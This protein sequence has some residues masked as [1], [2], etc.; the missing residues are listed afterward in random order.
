MG[1]FHENLVGIGPICDAK[2]SV[3]FNDEA[4]HIISPTGT[5]VITGWRE[6]TGHKLWRMSLLPTPENIIPIK[7]K[8]GTKETS[9]AAFS[10]YD[11]PSVEAL[12]RYFHAASGFP[13]RDT[14]L[15]AIKA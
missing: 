7:D 11:L 13:V 1:N 5:P 2:Y 4:V 8:P 14:W 15:K 9:L 3:L 10:A 6:E 12:V